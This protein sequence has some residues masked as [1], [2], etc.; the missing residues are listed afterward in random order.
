[1]GLNGVDKILA[2]TPCKLKV[3]LDLKTLA[4]IVTHSAD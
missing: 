1:M 3:H 2:G 4:N